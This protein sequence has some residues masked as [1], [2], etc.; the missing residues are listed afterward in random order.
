VILFD[1]KEKFL[2]YHLDLLPLVI[3]YEYKSTYLSRL[4]ANGEICGRDHSK[5]IKK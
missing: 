4:H 3:L 2:S 1:K 5:K